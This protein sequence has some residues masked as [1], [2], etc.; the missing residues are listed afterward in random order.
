MSHLHIA[1][2]KGNAR[3]TRTVV[4]AQAGTYNTMAY[5]TSYEFPPARERQHLSAHPLLLKHLLGFLLALCTV[6][7]AHAHDIPADVRLNIFFKPEG[8]TLK[9]LVRAPMS[10]MTEIDFPRQGPGYLVVSK[11]DA[12]LRHAAKLWLIDNFEIF[13]NGA[14]LPAP[15]IVHTRVAL[16][17]DTS[18]TAYESALA[19][20]KSPPLADNLDLYWNQQLLDVL[21]EYP[22]QSDQ[23]PF[24][25]HPRVDRLG[26]K[27]STALRFL[28]P[29]I[30]TRALE[31]HGN[32][33]RV[34]LDPR[35]H[36]AAWHFVVSGFRHILQGIDHLLFLL[37]LIIPFSGQ[38]GQR[39]PLVVIVTSFTVAHS[40]TLIAAAFG[41]VPDALWFPPLIELAIALT[42]IYMALENI[43]GSNVHRR[44][45][46]TFAFGLIHGFGFSFALRESLQFAGDH[47]LTSLLAFNL[48][49]EIGQLAVLMVL[50][51]VLAWLSKHARAQRIGVII[52]SALVAHTA[53]HW[54]LERGEALLKFPL[55]TFDT[56]FAVSV[57]RGLLALLILVALLWMVSGAVRR[58]LAPSI[59]NHLKSNTYITPS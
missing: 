16:P 10:A 33:G 50:L 23:S 39:R 9:L 19:N 30:A 6:A 37:C 48:G 35:W 4:P 24:A 3:H 54:M 51:P 57:M 36:Q 38:R 58:W 47:L 27:V 44:W 56:A 1:Q 26:L 34:E 22:I 5:G 21:L 55:P 8:K 2:S 12:A 25:I 20:L 46:L 17:S 31:F 32:P 15:K 40:I 49:V 59:K 52:L 7:F 45:L 29:G 11:A 13:E 53:W 18:F 28:P 41:F 42:L 14:L 43:V